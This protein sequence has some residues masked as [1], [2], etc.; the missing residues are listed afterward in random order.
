MRGSRALAGLACATTLALLLVPVT[1]VAAGR[2]LRVAD[3]PAAAMGAAVVPGET[4][5]CGGT[6]AR[7]A[8]LLVT[9]AIRAGIAG[10]LARFESDLCADGYRVVERSAAFATPPE[11]RAYLADLWN[12]SAHALVGAFLVGDIPH[13]YQLVK[14]TSSNPAIPSTTEETISYQYY[15]DLDGLFS[16]SAGYV[17]P[18]GHAW[19]FDEHT[20]AV[21]WELWVGVLPTYL[22][23]AA[24]TVSAL[25][26]YFDRNH[27]FRSRVLVLPRAF[28]W[29]DELLSAKTPAEYD[30]VMA[31]HRSG[32]Y[33]WTPLSSAPDARIYFDSVAPPLS[34][35][36]GYADLSAGSADI[37][38]LDAHGNWRI[39]GH[40]D[41]TWVTSHP[42]RSFL[43]WSDACAVGNLDHPDNFLAAAL[44]S[45]TST[46]LI[47]KGTTNNSGGMGTNE[48]GFYGHNIASAIVAGSSVGEAVVG[49]V[50]VPLAWP[51]SKDREFFTA[52]PVLLGDP[53]IRLRGAPAGLPPVGAP[54]SLTL[55][56]SKPAISWG[57]ETSLTAR[58]ASTAAAVSVAGRTVELEATRDG[59]TWA[60]IASLTTDASGAASLAYRPSTNLWYRAVF[61]GAAELA[62]ATSAQTRVVVRQ[63]ALLR[64]DNAGKTVLLPAGRQIT[65]TTTVRPARPELP[66]PS[67]VY[68]VQRLVGRSW[69]PFWEGRV[70]TAANGAAPFTWT[71]SLPG[72]WYVTSM[73]VPTPYNANSAWSAPQRYDVR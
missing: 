28:L 58:L 59:V 72:S 71:F 13:A 55:S 40:I 67:V 42:V 33:A 66:P 18:G 37:A 73:A 5:V 36:Q 8:A 25:N 63:I 29:I 70:R 49:H 38:V 23:S 44:Y 14:L 16:A 7:V 27:A 68:R 22:G 30:T 17:S 62:D 26:R 52:T 57:E 21:G 56:A 69:V 61:I 65:F 64:P 19:S 50:N 47:A 31:A 24:E 9:P 11:V 2:H 6:N 54:S 48:D 3:A 34:V 12:R 10:R 35:N 4:A 1:P 51:W 32:Q 41:S 45:P 60:T 20:G 39:N 43:L 15:A 46:V 53:T